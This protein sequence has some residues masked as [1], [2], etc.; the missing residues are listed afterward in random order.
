MRV[1]FT[2]ITACLLLLLLSGQSRARPHPDAQPE[3]SSTDHANSTRQNSVPDNRQM[4]WV[5]IAESGERFVFAD[6]G[7]RFIAWGFNYDHDHAGRL[8]EDYWDTHWQTV[9]EDFAEM[10]SLGA[11]VV[12]IHLQTGRF[13]KGPRRT[14]LAAL[15]RLTRLLKLAER[16]GLY[17]DLTGLGCYHKQDVP[18][19]YDALT[20]AQRWECQAHF[21]KAV[22]AVCAESPA[23]FCYNLMNEPILPGVG[24]PESDWLAGE[25]GGKHFVQRIAL[26][27]AGRTRIEV[28]RAWVEKLVS[29]IRKRD[30][31]H[32][33][34]VGVIP[35]AHVF[36]KAKPIFYAPEVAEHLDFVSVHFY[37]EKGKVDKALAALAVYDIG[38]PLVVEEIFPLKCGIEELDAFIEG[39]QPLADG[40]IGFY[41]GKTIDEYDEADG[42]AG[43]ITKQWLAY[44]RD[45][46]AEILS[47]PMST[48]C[49][50]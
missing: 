14:D 12:R 21:W 27:L 16:T 18:A 11:R 2:G 5:R 7:A 33:V 30:T 43:A 8:L 37:P 50:P 13:M 28:A 49:G 17:L 34:T 19:W 22:A 35:W 32:L 44:F 10:K 47:Q 26:D 23:V 24:K 45:K 48:T 4:E 31:R 20:E 46:T 29:T 6:S 36:P 3:T 9:V 38:K 1:G 40:W 41:W 42:L 25:F 39:S 15:D